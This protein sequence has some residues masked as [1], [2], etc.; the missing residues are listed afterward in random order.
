MGEFWTFPLL[1]L[2]GETREQISTALFRS[3]NTVK[4]H[5][6]SLYRKLGVNSRHDA[7]MRQRSRLPLRRPHRPE[8]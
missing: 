7:V 5:Q 2:H 4:S 3:V 6:R 1:A 8:G